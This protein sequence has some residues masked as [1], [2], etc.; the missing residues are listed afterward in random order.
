MKI[1]V[2][3]MDIAHETNS[4]SLYICWIADLVLM[5]GRV[6]QCMRRVCSWST[7]RLQGKMLLEQH[8]NIAH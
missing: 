3:K 5:H 6:S 4:K 8:Q 1:P 7:E 2:T